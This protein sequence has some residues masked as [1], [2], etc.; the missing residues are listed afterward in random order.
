M[1]ARSPLQSTKRELDGRRTPDTS[2]STHPDDANKMVTEFERWSTSLP[3]KAPHVHL[4]TKT[5]QV[6][7]QRAYIR[8]DKDKPMSPAEIERERH[9][10]NGI[11]KNTL[12]LPPQIL[13]AR[14][15]MDSADHGPIMVAFRNETD[16]AHYK[17]YGVFF[18][19]DHCYA[20]D[21]EHQQVPQFSRTHTLD[22]QL[23]PQ[24]K[25]RTLRQY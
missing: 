8:K 11:N 18:R 20:R 9:E 2:S 23:Q 10:N 17:T 22:T 14:R 19:G 21:E 6:V 4:D 24:T 5:H 25:G 13:I 16:A 15:T 12:V 1:R 3:A 7:I